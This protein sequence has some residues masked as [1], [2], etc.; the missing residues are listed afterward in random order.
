[1]RRFKRRSPRGAVAVPILIFSGLSEDS[2][3]AQ[4]LEA[5]DA[6]VLTKPLDPALVIMRTLAQSRVATQKLASKTLDSMEC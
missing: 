4:T 2:C 6:D 3:R 5:G 1:M